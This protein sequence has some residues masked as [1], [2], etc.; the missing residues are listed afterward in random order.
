MQNRFLRFF[1]LIFFVCVSVIFSSDYCFSKTYKIYDI[2]VIDIT[3]VDYANDILRIQFRY[4]DRD[5]GRYVYWEKKNVDC[6][7]QVYPLTNNEKMNQKLIASNRK[8]LE[9]YDQL[10]FVDI[11]R[12]YVKNYEH[13]RIKCEFNIGWKV[14]KT[15]GDFRF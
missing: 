9:E 13:G 7:C 14:I 10:F 4:L 3:G 2:D 6:S 1:V 12:S 15:K 11:P 5:K 8:F